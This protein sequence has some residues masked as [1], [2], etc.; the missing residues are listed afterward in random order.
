MVDCRYR[1][2]DG[3]ER[4][5]GEL[6]GQ[7]VVKLERVAQ[8]ELP[9]E[10]LRRLAGE[11]GDGDVGVRVAFED[12][13]LTLVRSGEEPVRLVPIST[14]RFAVEQGPPVRVD[15]HLED[16][17]VVGLTLVTKSGQRTRFEAVDP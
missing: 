1:F 8:L 15:F 17:R 13:S 7:V 3:R 2:Y 9:E 6:S 5:E 11:Y 16:G 10:R 14:T 12:G 4:V